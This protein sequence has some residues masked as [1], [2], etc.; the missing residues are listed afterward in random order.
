[1]EQMMANQPGNNILSLKNVSKSFGDVKAVQNLSLDIRKGEI[2]GLLG[3]NGAGKTTT[4]NMV[5][6]LLKRDSGDIFVGGKP[7]E[8][9]PAHHRRMIGYCPQDLIVWESLT[10]VEQLQLMGYLTNMGKKSANIK[11]L[12]LL[13]KLGLMEKKNR[14]AKTLS[15]GMKRRL[16]LALGLIH[17][18]EILILDEPQAGL[19]PRSRIMIR[20]IIRSMAGEKTIILTTHEMDEADRLAHRIGIIDRGKLLVTDTSK[21]LKEQ[22]GEGDIL[23]IRTDPEPDHR[24]IRK[25]I[26]GKWNTISITGNTVRTV[27]NNIPEYLPEILRKIRKTGMRI[28]DVSIRKKTLEDVFVSLTG[29]R[30]TG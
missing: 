13:D 30:L 18:P 4:I 27:G 19:D 28:E 24:E 14:L 8:H 7:F 1:M 9:H 20:E 6:F 16:N 5:C 22:L 2:F 11:A 29:R 10:C 25:L 21:N 23:E 26:P 17:D 12:E 15:G 3:P